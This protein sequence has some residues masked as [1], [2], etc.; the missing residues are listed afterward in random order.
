MLPAFLFLIALPFEQIPSGTAASSALDPVIRRIPR[1]TFNTVTGIQG[2]I[3]NASGSG[4]PAVSITLRNL[5]NGREYPVSTE[6]DGVFR[7]LD[8]TPGTYEIHIAREGFIPVAQDNVTLARGQ[9]AEFEL[10][11]DV[12]PVNPNMPRMV[13]EQSGAGTRLPTPELL[14]SPRYL[15]MVQGSR[16]DLNSNS[17]L[18]ADDSQIPGEPVYTEVPNR[19]KQ[20]YPPYRR[21]DKKGE[22]PYVKSRLIDPFDRSRIK[23][24]IP[25]IGNRTFLNI[26]LTSDTSEDV[27]RLPTPSNVPS[28]RPNSAGFFGHEEQFFTAENL[29]FS[30]DLFHGDAAFRPIDW[31]IRVTPEVNINFLQTQELGIVNAD[32]RKG[33]NRLDNHASLQEAFFEVKLL[34]L[35]DD[36][37]FVSVRAGIQGFNSDFRG[38]IFSDQEPG[39]RFFGNLGSNRYQ[40]NL[41]GFS[42]LE[43]DTNSGLNSFG[44]R[45]QQVYIANLYRQDF[46]T[47]GY[48]IQ[49]SFHYDKDDPSFQFDQNH[50]LVRPEP[51]GRVKPHAIRAY[52][53]GLTGDGHIGRLNLTHAFYQVLGHDT[54]NPI[55][56]SKVDIHAQMA[57][58]ELSL[59]RDW[60]RYRVSFFYSSGDAHP[61]NNSGRGF[62]AIFDSPNFAGGIFSFWN[63]EGIRLTGSSVSLDSSD[64][65]LPSLR[66]SKI[67]GQANFV[68]PGIYI[69]NAGIDADVTPKLRAFLNVNLVRFDHTE[70]LELVLFQKPIHAGI[71]DDNGLGIRYRPRLSD[72]IIFTAGVNAFVPFQG[73]RDIYNNKTLFSVFANVRFRF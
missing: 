17:R 59:D 71:G 15:T 51:V 29:S 7:R 2:L 4:L 27:R 19:W 46:L 31:R 37:D 42:M 54:F 25:I 28:E 68:N 57:A 55:A 1:Q 14:P 18:I 9:V 13:V 62:D 43:K 16:S 66:S 35:S 48:T 23:G 6:G 39:I 65:L 26:T 70:P 53:Y 41:A 63:R 32:P 44:Y 47:P 69:Y 12:V 30:V 56:G 8:L 58:V 5:Q 64:S 61:R 38:F 22:Y 11:L 60:L 33:T 34:D 67:E 3:R 72:N 50:F 24:D 10:Q 40:Y 21:Y 36:Y 45:S 73:F 20:D 52:Y 49:A